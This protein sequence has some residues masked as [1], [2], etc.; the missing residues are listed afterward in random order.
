METY[1]LKLKMRCNV[2]MIWSKSEKLLTTLLCPSHTVAP[3][4][5]AV[6]NQDEY[7]KV[8]SLTGF[9]R[10]KQTRVGQVS[11]SVIIQSLSSISAMYREALQANGKI[12]EPTQC[13]HLNKRASSDNHCIQEEQQQQL[14]MKS[15]LTCGV[16]S[17]FHVRVH[18]KC[19]VLLY[20]TETR[21]HT[22][23]FD[24]CVS[25]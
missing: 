25:F 14:Q 15:N 3:V 2:Q 17:C 18:F 16:S 6:L 8:I 7:F 24:L 13:W 4:S 9:Y 20:L 23:Y 11:L 12:Q 22:H 21:T 10:I 19:I 5:V 1:T